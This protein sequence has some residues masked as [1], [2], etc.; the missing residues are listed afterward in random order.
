MKAIK[1]AK[2]AGYISKT[3]LGE[4][5]FFALLSEFG[6]KKEEWAKLMEAIKEAKEDGYISKTSLGRSSFWALLSEFG[7][8]PVE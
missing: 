5:S 8:K 7:Q 2:E 4:G 3:A 1:E 6:L